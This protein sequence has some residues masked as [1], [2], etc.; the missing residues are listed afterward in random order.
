M[1]SRAGSC[2]AV[3]ASIMRLEQCG[4]FDHCL[5]CAQARLMYCPAFL[6]TV[7][8]TL[9]FS[10]P[11]AVQVTRRGG[12]EMAGDAARPRLPILASFARNHSVHTCYMYTVGIR[13]LCLQ[14]SWQGSMDP[15]P[16]TVNQYGSIA[17]ITRR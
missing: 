3:D 14:S 15:C 10:S 4:R 9:V 6:L 17:R 13:P 8:P 11:V 12:G 16:D 1:I 7:F 2:P 5:L